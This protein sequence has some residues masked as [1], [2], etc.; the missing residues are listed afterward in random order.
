MI[1]Y[2]LH[3]GCVL[4][5]MEKYYCDNC[6]LLYNQEGSCTVCGTIVKNKLVIEVHKQ[7]NSNN[8]AEPE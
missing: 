1:A 8:Y 2:S 5:M 6:R 3:S 7:N 4:K